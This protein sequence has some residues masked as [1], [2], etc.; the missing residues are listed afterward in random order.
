[1]KLLVAATLRSAPA[2]SGSVHS[3]AAASGE[4][5]SLTMAT[6]VAPPSRK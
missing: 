5:T 2:R 4:A 1:M 3:A 6:V